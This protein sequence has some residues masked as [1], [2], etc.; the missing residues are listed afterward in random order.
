MTDQQERRIA[1]RIADDSEIFDF[2]RALYLVEHMP[3]EAERL[4]RLREESKKR[5]ERLDRAYQ[6]LHRAA[7]ALQ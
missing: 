6:G 4:I 2:A 5:Q 1:Q 3:E 7:Q